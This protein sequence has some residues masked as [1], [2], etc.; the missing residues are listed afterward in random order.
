M[1]AN[2]E[3]QSFA[4]KWLEIYSNEN[5]TVFELASDNLGVECEILGFDMDC[6]KSFE[7][8]YPDTGAFND[9][10]KLERI[11][12][13]IEDTH[14]IGCAIFSQWR[15]YTHWA[16]SC[17]EI[18]T[19]KSRAWFIMMFRRLEQLTIQP[20]ILQDCYCPPTFKG[21]LQRV[22]LISNCIGYGLYPEEDAEVEQHFSVTADGRVF[23]SSYNYGDG[24]KFTKARTHNFE[25]EA[26]MA[27]TLLEVKLV[28]EEV[29]IDTELPGKELPRVLDGEGYGIIEDCGGTGGLKEIEKAFKKKKAHSIKNTVSGLV[30]QNWTCLYLILTI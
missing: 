10:R 15:Y 22:K 3:I 16:Y 5:N 4:K 2:E 19:L 30:L 7:S 11:I 28:L 12:D 26:C 29:I 21:K 25:I 24:V 13:K 17:D 18:A 20:S 1:A 14:L 6:G 9:Y 8:A 23:F 27:K